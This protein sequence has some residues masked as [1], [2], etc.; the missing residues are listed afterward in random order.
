ME[1]QLAEKTKQPSYDW[2]PVVGGILNIISGVIGLIATAILVAFSVTLG[3]GIARDVLSSLGFLNIGIPL[4]IIWL[5]AIPMLIIS[6]VAI[7]SGVY[8]VN[9]KNW[10]LALAGAICSI[11]PSQVIGV[12]AVILIV[13][14]KKEFK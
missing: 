10:G 4:T 3:A 2:M 1:E 9:K 14:S 11:V 12:I 8:A 6:I 13:M 7:I 5:V